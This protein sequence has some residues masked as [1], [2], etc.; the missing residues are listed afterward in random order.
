M[1]TFGAQGLRRILTWLLIVQ[2]FLAGAGIALP[3]PA[4]AARS[5]ERY[6]C[7]N[8]GCGCRSAEECWAHCCCF[9]NQEKIEWGRR[10]G[11]AVPEFVVAA[12]K[13]EASAAERPK[14]AH[15]KHG[16]APQNR[17]SP[18][19]ARTENDDE[20]GSDENRPSR[21]VSWLSALR[22]HGLTDYWQAAVVSWP[23]EWP[24]AMDPPPPLLGRIEPRSSLTD[25]LPPPAPPAPPPKNS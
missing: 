7:E 21:G 1:P 14:C 12:A 23:G 3:C 11:V 17:V 2:Q 18:P 5:T 25:F 15:C 10:H 6:P 24:A 16:A 4:A 22:C 8:C 13:R 20:Q 19:V 9:T